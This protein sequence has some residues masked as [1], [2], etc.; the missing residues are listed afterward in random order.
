MQSFDEAGLEHVTL[1]LSSKRV[2]HIFEAQTQIWKRSNILV[3]Y[4]I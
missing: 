3:D 4:R 1:A 2:C